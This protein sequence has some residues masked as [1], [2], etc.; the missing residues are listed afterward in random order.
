MPRIR[1]KTS[2][3]GT[4]A[5]R[6]KIK[7]KVSDSRKKSKKAAK[8]DPTWKS[9]KPKDPG[10]PN[11][12]PYKDQILAE[13]AEERRQAAEAKAQRKEEKKQL[14]A[15]QKVALDAGKDGSHGQDSD[16]AEERRTVSTGCDTR[17]VHEELIQVDD[18]GAPATDGS[19]GYAPATT[20]ETNGAPLL[21]NPDLPHLAAVLDKADVVIEVL[22][23]RDPLSYRS[24]AL[25]A[26]VASKEGQKL[27]LVLNKIDACAREPTAAWAAHLR[28]EH[29]TLLSR[30]ASSF[31]PSPVAHD[32]TK[33]KGKRKEP[34]DDA[35]GLE[36]VS[37]LLRHWAQEKTGEG[38]LHVAV[39]GLTNS[40]KSAFLNSLARKSI[41]DVYTPSSSTNNPTTTPHALEVTLELD[42]VSILFIDTP[43]LAWLRS[44]EVPPEEK[45][46]R[47][48][49]DVLLRNKGR[50]DRLKDPLPAVSYIVSRADT[51]DLMVF[52][53]LPAFAK[54]DVDAFLM[55]VAR[56]QGLI[57]KGGKLDLAAAARIV[58]R[59]WSTGKLSRYAV[60]PTVSGSGT[61]ADAVS[62]ALATIYEGDAALLEKLPPRKEM[63][64]TRDLVRLSSE[65]VDDRT[66]ALDAPW[67]SRD[68]VSDSDADD[69]ENEACASELESEVE[70]EEIGSGADD[71]GDSEEDAAADDA[72]LGVLENEEDQD[73]VPQS[74]SSARKRKRPQPPA[75]SS[76]SQSGPRKK[77]AFASS[78][79]LSPHKK[80]NVNARAPA[81]TKSPPPPSRSTRKSA[82]NAPPPTAAQRRK[83]GAGEGEYDFSKFF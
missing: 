79:R 10:I 40:G 66:L 67:F 4:T 12:F 6:A 38:P 43:G 46:R 15:Q 58:L 11:N 8:R 70:A 76:K 31:L 81:G 3:R 30:A 52:Y 80:S 19:S 71:V 68:G 16:D 36:A 18:E 45:E 73:E 56:A 35:W 75:P 41:L 53:S 25:E 20:T 14:R 5:R 48:G 34:S 29:P 37:H 62:T 82:A 24:R 44:E 42:G 65:R 9:K 77:V 13:I 69:D 59:D 49:Q 32:P 50:I 63:R 51:E 83:P 23:A 64:R 22:D 1:K 33:G 7:H 39:V 21:L 57:K 26:R 17:W 72:G 61:A 28:L 2:K 54:G 47:R 27:L 60:P 78:T 55:G 74:S